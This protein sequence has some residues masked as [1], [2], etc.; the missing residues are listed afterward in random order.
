MPNT[1]DQDTGGAIKGKARVDIYFG[2][3]EYAALASQYHNHLGELFF[4][5]LKKEEL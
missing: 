3:D 1:L 2:E 4:L 5:M